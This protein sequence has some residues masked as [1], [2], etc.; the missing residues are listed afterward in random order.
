MKLPNFFIIGAAKAGTTAL[1]NYLNNHPEVYMSPIKEPHYFSKDL[2]REARASGKGGNVTL[3]GTALKKYLQARKKKTVHGALINSWDDYILLFR[4]AADQVAIG[5]ASPSYLESAVAAQEI[6]QKIPHARIV[7]ILRN[8][9]TRAYSHYIM[10][11]KTN[12]IEMHCPFLEAVKAKSYLLELGLYYE[13][14]NRY[15][16]VFGHKNV[17]VYLNEDLKND[18]ESL[19]LDLSGFLGLSEHP[20]FL[21]VAHNTASVPRFSALNTLLT[22]HQR[23][24][25]ILKKIF[26]LYIPP[27]IQNKLARVFF[28]EQNIPKLNKEDKEYMYE[29]F[30]EDIK[31]LSSLIQ[32]D[33]SH[34][35]AI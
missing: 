13:K 33:L 4:D 29:I 5:E 11:I 32:R 17:K 35:C 1:Y 22:S 23:I 21:P 2:F 14:V 15:L 10:N 30:R 9:L 26:S 3:E 16:Q 27:T 34:W 7:A 18:P 8:P 6:K 12:L 25:A 24:N 19:I 20:T 28:N 31:R